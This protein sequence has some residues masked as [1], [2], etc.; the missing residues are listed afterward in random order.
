MIRQ[1]LILFCLI[2]TMP[3]IA[4]NKEITTP[5][6]TTEKEA[7]PQI[8]YKQM[9]AP[10]PTLKLRVFHDTAKTKTGTAIATT[11]VVNSE[12]KRGRKKK[13]EAGHNTT[14][15]QVNI[16]DYKKFVTN[17]DFKNGA[18]LVVMMFNPTCSHCEDQTQL[19]EKNIFLFKKSKL[20]LMANPIMWDYIPNFAKSFHIDEYPTITLGT[21]SS[22]FIGKVFIYSS[23]PQI[24]IYD[25]KH[26]LIRTFAGEVPIDSLSAYID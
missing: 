23:L 10:M 18:N 19:F 5:S 22:D 3:A 25:H 15:G 24:N 9:G 26:K 12:P 8:D 16:A 21:D 7:E 11:D 2:I 6:K 20:I 17:D 4:Q 1:V 14:G 13:H